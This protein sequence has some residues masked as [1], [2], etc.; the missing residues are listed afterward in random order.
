VTSKLLLTAFIMLLVGCS[1]GSKSEQEETAAASR[2]TTGAAPTANSEGGTLPARPG[3]HPRG[4]IL[5]CS[6][7]SEA[8]FGQAYAD[9]SNLV[10]GP[11][12]LVGGAE[13]TSEA[14]VLAHDGQKYPLLVKAAHTVTVQLPRRARRTAGLAYGPFPEGRVRVRDA[15]DTITFVACGPDEPSGSSAGGPVTFWSGFVMTHIPD[16][17]PLNVYVDDEPSPRHAVVPVGPGP[18]ESPLT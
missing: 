16:C 15:H 11:L 18:C 6:M 1:V 13:P 5:D 4:V 14:T 7:R 9:P 8:D 12:L 17:V 10:V 2:S 3:T